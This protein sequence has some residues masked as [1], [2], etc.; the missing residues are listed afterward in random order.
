MQKLKALIF[1]VDGT[2][3]DTE[4]VHL[5]AFNRAFANAGL[6][7]NWST[8]MYKDLLAVTGGKERIRHYLAKYKPE[9]S[10]DDLD[11][12]IIALHADKTAEYV[13]MAASGELTLRTGVEELFRQAIDAGLRLAI[14]TTTTPENVTALLRNTLGEEA[15]DWFEVIGAGN[16]VEDKKPAADIYFYVLDEMKLSADECMAF[17]DSEN[18]VI[19]ARG[20]GLPVIVTTNV[21]THDHD[22][23]GAVLVVDQMGNSSSPFTVLHGDAG[24]SQWMDMALIQHC[25]QQA[26]DAG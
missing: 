11:S 8:E 9:F 12:L 6:D 24:N 23:S 2:L 10:T 25:H 1:D 7:W 13:N 14:A 3:A 20:A 16:I 4:Q 17:E 26:L 18:G 5:K 21:F 22:F 19:S 15:I